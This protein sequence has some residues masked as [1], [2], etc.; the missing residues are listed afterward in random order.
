M[1]L[2]AYHKKYEYSAL[3][4]NGDTLPNHIFF[5]ILHINKN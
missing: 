4:L 2:F 1:I 5:V 3:V